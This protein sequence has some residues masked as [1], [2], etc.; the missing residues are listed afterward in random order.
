M[1]NE[2]AMI[3][4]SRTQYNGIGLTFQSFLKDR[5][6]VMTYYLERREQEGLRGQKRRQKRLLHERP[7]V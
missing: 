3:V 4:L 1:S 6:T 2:K 7:L 5:I